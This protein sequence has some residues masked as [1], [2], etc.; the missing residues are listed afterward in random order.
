MKL[1]SRCGDCCSK[2]MCGIGHAVFTDGEEPTLEDNY[3]ICP[4]LEKDGEIFS[5]GLV[6]HPSK[7]LNLGEN[8]EWKDEWMSMFIGGMLGIELG[9]CSTMQN[10]RIGMQMR[11]WAMLAKVHRLSKRR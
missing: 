11:S 10:K 2:I 1:C 5:C 8:A 9:C 3:D 7:Y 6:V 4:A